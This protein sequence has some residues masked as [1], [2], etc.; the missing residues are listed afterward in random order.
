MKIDCPKRFEDKE[1]KKKDG[2]DANNKRVG[3]TGG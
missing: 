2:E 3:V 1:N